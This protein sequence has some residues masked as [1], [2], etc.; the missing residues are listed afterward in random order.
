MKAVGRLALI[1][2]GC[3][4]TSAN[5]LVAALQPRPG[6]G[7]PSPEEVRIWVQWCIQIK[8]AHDAILM[9]AASGALKIVVFPNGSIGVKAN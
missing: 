8:V 5:N 4:K 6:M 7:S 1:Q 3:P 9:R 2:C